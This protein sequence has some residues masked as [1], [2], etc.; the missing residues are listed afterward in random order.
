MLWSIP[1]DAGSHQFIPT[2]W[3]FNA[4]E[5]RRRKEEARSWALQ[6]QEITFLGYQPRVAL[7]RRKKS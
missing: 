5:G 6:A 1:V 4:W 7:G 3:L 2:A